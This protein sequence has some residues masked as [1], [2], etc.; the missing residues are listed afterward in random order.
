MKKFFSNVIEKAKSFVTNLT[1][2]AK[3][4]YVVVSVVTVAVAAS[5]LIA[6]SLNTSKPE[7]PTNP[8]DFGTGETASIDFDNEI[9]FEIGGESSSVGTTDGITEDPSVKTDEVSKTEK[10]TSDEESTNVQTENN[11]EST[12]EPEPQ[13][14]DPSQDYNP[15]PQPEDTTN[16]HVVN[17]KPTETTQTQTT[18]KPTETTKAPQT[19]PKPTETTT[20]P[21]TQPKPTETTTKTPQTEPKPIET[22]TKAPQTEPK[23]TETTKPQE[24]EPQPAGQF[25]LKEKKYDYNGANVTI[26]QVENKSQ[27][28]YTI[29]ITGKFK[30]ANGNIVKTDS[31]TFEGFP[32]GWSN[33]FVFQPGV[34][35]SSVTWGMETVAFKETTMAQFFYSGNQVV[36]DSSGWGHVD[37]NGN[38]FIPTTPEEIKNSPKYVCLDFRIS[39]M[40]HTYSGPI[41]FTGDVVF[42]DSDGM[43]CKIGSTGEANVPPSVIFGA[44]ALPV[45]TNTLWENRDS[46]KLPDNLKNV[47][48]VFSLTSIAAN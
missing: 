22:T 2:T 16:T 38:Y 32:A 15:D 41:S 40:K 37:T 12:N 33:Y 47:T 8:E 4:K 11:T 44:G 9:I 28:A 43:L 3:I 29:K 21:Q 30:D 23:P 20:A 25:S 7:T 5:L 48:G 27:Q 39:N 31:K 10:N 1:P 36:V 24:S 19:E 34:K 6:V 17:P 14:T 35:Y 45:P 42:F 13:P 26:L 18:S 46:Y